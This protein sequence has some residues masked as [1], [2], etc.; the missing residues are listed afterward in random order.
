[1]RFHTARP[2]SISV[3]VPLNTADHG[4]AAAKRTEFNMPLD[5][6]YG[7]FMS[8]LCA[9]MD[10]DKRTAMLG[11]KYHTDRARN[12]PHTLSNEEEYRI[13]LKMGISLMQRART[14]IVVHEIHNLVSWF[15]SSAI[16]AIVNAE[17][18]PSTKPSMSCAKC[19]GR[20]STSSAGIDTTKAPITYVPT[21]RKLKAELSCIVHPN[22]YCYVA[23]DS[24]HQQ[25]NIAQVTFWAK[26]IVSSLL[27]S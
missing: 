19:S 10:L 18:D 22:R 13:A 15:I 26:Q 4:T 8:R 5:L 27:C 11:Y 20:S 14:R 2:T 21:F 12:L 23:K 17:Q 3:S 9:R 16:T 1:M 6:E 7:D 24:S 25:L